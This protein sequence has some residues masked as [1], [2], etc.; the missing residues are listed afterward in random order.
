VSE[1]Q[2]RDEL[3]IRNL[4]AR[5]CHSVSA[6]DDDA[7]AATWAEDGEWRVLGNTA[8]GRAAALEHYR[9][10]VANVTWVIQM[11]F[12]GIIEVDGD[13][14]TGRWH[15]L[16]YIQFEGGTAG[17]N[18]GRYLDEYVRGADGAWRFALR[19]F[20]PMYLG[21]TDLSVPAAAPRRSAS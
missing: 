21:P 15:I 7:W 16:E 1:A 10:I 8:R 6:A 5:Y 4:V 14:A 2:L 9:K 18:V 12:D 3:A 11:A 19:D 20:Q 13:R 17:Q